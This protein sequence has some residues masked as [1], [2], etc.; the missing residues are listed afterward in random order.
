MSVGRGASKALGP[1]GSTWRSY[2][3][4]APDVRGRRLLGA[5]RLLEAASSLL[6]AASSLLEAASSLLGAASH[7]P[8]RS[9]SPGILVPGKLMLVFS[10][11]GTVVQEAFSFPGIVGPGVMFREVDIHLVANIPE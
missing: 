10:V 11:Q 4:S 2:R 9:P 8:A 5:A 7:P 1:S 6:E 3:G